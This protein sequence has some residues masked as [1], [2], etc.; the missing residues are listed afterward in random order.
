MVNVY[1]TLYV[2]AIC[3]VVFQ[4]AILFCIPIRIPWGVGHLKFAFVKDGEI[5]YELRC[6]PCTSPTPI[7]FPA[8]YDPPKTTG[9]A[10]EYKVRS[11]TKCGPKSTQKIK[12]FLEQMIL[13]IS[14]SDYWSFI[15]LIWGVQIIYPFKNW[16]VFLRQ[17]LNEN[18]F[19]DICTIKYFSPL[20][21]GLFPIDGWPFCFLKCL[22]K[23]K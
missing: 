2:S 4:K 21:A 1:L 11:T 13:D 20:I 15:Y 6:L 23:T 9:V 19:S 7:R 16:V 10:P 17:L 12:L 3:H 22:I 5:V 18:P 14:P 8:T